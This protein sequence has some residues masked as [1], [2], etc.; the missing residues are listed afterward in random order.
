MERS[1]RK[2]RCATAAEGLVERVHQKQRQKAHAANVELCGLVRLR[3]TAGFLGIVVGQRADYEFSS[4]RIASGVL[5]L[6]IAPLVSCFLDRRLDRVSEIV[7]CAA[8]IAS[9]PHT[10]T[11]D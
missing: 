1:R 2:L 3:L 11:T 8:A 7:T 9:V 6:Q 4:A 5:L 10:G